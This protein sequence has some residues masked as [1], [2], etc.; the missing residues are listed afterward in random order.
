MQEICVNPALSMI[1][2]A[3]LINGYRNKVVKINNME[4]IIHLR[5]NHI[6]RAHSVF[7]ATVC[8]RIQCIQ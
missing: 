2:W 8:I 4:S 7:T 6:D 1:L 5:I 3:Y